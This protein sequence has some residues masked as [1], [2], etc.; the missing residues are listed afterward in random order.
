MTG[1]RGRGRRGRRTT[2]R[3]RIGR[4]RMPKSLIQTVHVRA[5]FDPSSTNLIT[6]RNFSYK[7]PTDGSHQNFTLKSAYSTVFPDL[8]VSAI[9][10]CRID[11]IVCWSSNSTESP[12]YLSF[13]SEF[14]R[15]DDPGKNHRAVV[16]CVPTKVNWTGHPDVPITTYGAHL[17]HVT[18]VVLTQRAAIPTT[19]G[20]T[21]TQD[22][23]TTAMSSL[24]SG[25]ATT[26][27][28][29]TAAPVSSIAAASI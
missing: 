23:V 1:G 26:A 4:R 24:S 12:V 3:T 21:T 27:S 6:R 8:Q 29:T 9:L 16:A 19:S 25:T 7:L 14:S 5:G 22:T 18:G 20:S 13:G 28:Q 17:I 11:K 10:G 2:R 15:R